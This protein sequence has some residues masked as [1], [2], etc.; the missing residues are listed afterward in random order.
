MKF[1]A[2]FAFLLAAALLVS[3]PAP[4][5]QPG[6]LP[7]G[8]VLLVSGWKLQPAGRQ[9]PVDTFPMSSTVSPDGKY[10]L[11]LNAG[12][13][14]PSISVLDV[15]AEKELS[16]TPV[17]DGWLGL[18]FSPRGDRVYVGGGSQASVF[19]FTFSDG[20]LT[21][22][23]T[24]VV[25]PEAKRTPQDFIGDVALS[26]DGRLLYAAD[27][28]RNSLVVINPQSGTAISRFRTGRRPYRILFH[29]DGQSFFVTSWADG[30][31]GHYQADNGSLLATER[32]GPHPTDMLW[33]AGKVESPEGS[34]VIAARLFV[35]AS[36]TNAVYSIG[37]TDTKAMTRLETISVTMTPR[38]PLGMTPSAL[39]LSPDAKR[40]FVVCS[41]AN[42]VA[43]VDVTEQR[44]A[45][46]GFI[47]A[48]WYPLA[49]RSLPGSKLAVLNG[50]GLRS[51]PNPLGPD[52]SQKP[53]EAT[54]YVA[55]I[56]R[57]A[58]SFIDA[59]NEEKLDEYTKAAI[60]GS[61]Y[62]DAKLDQAGLRPGEKFP[63]EHVI[64]VVKENRT[65]DQVLGDL[66][67]GNG[68]PKLATFGEEVTPNHHKLAREFVLFDN[69]Y[70]NADVG[71]DGHNW[72]TAAIAPDYVQK[73]W[74][75]SYGRRRKHYDYEGGEPAAIPPAGYIWSNAAAAG[76]TMRNYGHWVT[77]R[78]KPGPSGEQIE[79]VRDPVLNRVTNRNFRGFDLD[80]ADVD[81]IKVLI[82]DLE[83]FEKTGQMPRL[84]LIRIG[85]D[86]TSG[87]APRKISPRSAVADN[88]YAL[89]MLVEAVSKSRF[90]PTTAIFVLEDDAQDGPDH[91]DSHRSP[92]FVISP[93]AKRQAV[94]SSMYNTAS[95]LRTMELILG[96][97]PMTHFDAGARPM[98]AAFQASPNLA[99]YTA[100][101]PRIPLDDRNPD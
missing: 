9:V 45:V 22:G 70:V 88:D 17:P 54:E 44:S 81:R 36:N 21:P 40:L 90:W 71:A 35:T 83:E 3:Q 69:F 77:N 99:P 25:V 28:F 63:I 27:L 32:I 98:S 101:K 2:L 13:N 93:Y 76:V 57:G 78:Q 86:H 43:V 52:P 26:P 7:G 59:L 8:G 91:V 33:R 24:F 64:Y 37:V 18:T 67:K 94:D 97:R 41:D 20:R 14:P 42:A 6:P 100:E 29:P 16:R 66:K 58:V 55:R 12:Y 96:I 89:G 10:L 49:A 95:M 74:P 53:T 23:R 5:E 38:Q 15:A 11:V 39:A 48:G 1:A 73:M 61:P 51:F 50:R 87:A 4:R 60:A 56:Q 82:K 19:E 84:L 80:Y 34:Q 72:S 30:T 47:P 68:E 75:N 46:L 65:Y 92:A 62:H 85:N 31:L 79:A